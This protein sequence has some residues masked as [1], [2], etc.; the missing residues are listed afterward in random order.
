MIYV[1]LPVYNEA[2]NISRVIGEIRATLKNEKYQIVAVNDGSKDGCLDILRKLQKPD[3]H[4]ESYLTNMNV[5]A[6]FSTGISYV[7]SR[8]KADDL[9]AI[10]ESDGTSS[11]SVLYDLINKIQKDQSDIVIASRYQKGGEYRN[12][13]LLR[14]IF[15]YVA[16]HL[17]R[18]YFPIKN[19]YDYTIFFRI[20][21]MSVIQKA[22]T[23]FGMFGLIQS[24]GFVANAE[25]L[26][27]LSFFT[28][29]ISEIPFIYD[30][31]KKKGA[32][33][34]GIIRT[35]NEYFTVVTYLQQIRKKIKG[36]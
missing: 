10:M 11:C 33:K 31:G 27:K 28:D 16:S 26:I 36:K 6:V 25:F 3:L 15:S 19:V 34:I 18:Y 2:E 9:M 8:A 5:G 4:I 24:L 7:L 35:I 13:P 21:R 20:Y 12:F 22:V 14:R 17:M 29:K 32:S 30:Y 23:H 1:V